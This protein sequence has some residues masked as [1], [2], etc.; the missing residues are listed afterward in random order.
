VVVAVGAH[1]KA[2]AIV[3]AAARIARDTHSPLEVVHVQQT[4][5]VE[6]QAVETEEAADG[7]A[8]VTGHLDRLAAQGVVATGQLLVS[9]GDHAAAG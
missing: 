8:A 7:R 4:A 1:A 5:V 3:D 9:V 2:A 6:Q